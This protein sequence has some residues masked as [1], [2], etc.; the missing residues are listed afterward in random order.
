LSRLVVHFSCGAASAVAAKLTLANA[1]GVQ[2]AIIN[3][4]LEEEDK[5]NRRFLADCERWFNH[6]VTV[7]RDEK[8]GASTDEVWKRERY[9][10]KTWATCSTAWT[11]LEMKG[12]A[13]RRYSM[14]RRP[15][16]LNQPP[17]PDVP[18]TQRRRGPLA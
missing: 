5:D 18:R 17:L 3:A 12:N 15:C 2:V 13:L 16:S 10:W 7:L 1:G 14:R 6:P 9:M 11:L 4:Y 8:Y